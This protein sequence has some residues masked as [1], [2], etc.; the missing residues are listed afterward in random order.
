MHTALIVE[1]EPEANKLLAMLLQLR[2]YRTVSA[3]RGAEALEK[4][5]DV[6]PDVV[7]LDLM[8]PDMDGYQV[9]RSLRTPGG[10]IPVPVVIVTA[11]LTAENRIESFAA[12]ADDYVPKPYTPD[13]IFEALEQSSAW[14]DQID[15][16][17]LDD[18]VALD[19][20]DDGETLRHLAHLRRL[21]LAR[22]P[23]EPEAIDGITVAIRTLWA[24]IDAWSR[25]RREERVATLAYSLTTE[26]LT[27]TV[28]DEAGWLAA[29]PPAVMS[30]L[31]GG[32]FDE[33]IRDEA[34]RT[35]TLVKRCRTAGHSP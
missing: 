20:R 9:C 33:M 25:Q 8:L 12:G 23:I 16:P 22:C 2:G 18:E 5:R 3:F 14:R 4:I 11:R 24:S 6:A 30:T 31:A 7:F 1:D 19:G 10:V 17:R 34:G 26:A 15:A 32:P 21:L 28:R 29:A 13:Q 27:M 35:L